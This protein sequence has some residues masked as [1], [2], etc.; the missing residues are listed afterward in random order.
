MQ[1]TDTHAHLYLPQFDDDREE[2][3][4]RALENGVT[5]I[6]LPNI[7]AASVEPMLQLATHYPGICFPMI[8]LHPTSVKE[9]YREQLA[10]MK[11]WLEKEKFYAI[12]EVGI[13]L[14]WD[15]SKLKEQE[16]A[17]SYQVELSITNDLPLVIHCRESFNE[18]VTIL[19][20]YR[21]ENIK[22]VFHAFSGTSEQAK[23]VINMGFLL[24]IGGVVTFKNGGIDKILAETGPS[25]LLTE[26]DSPYLAPAPFRGKRNEPSMIRYTAEKIAEFCRLPL[27]EIAAITTGNAETLFKI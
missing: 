13:D 25:R 21:G 24:G 15:K 8:G 22:G 16:E 2:A 20:R 27:S 14:Y 1:L 18:T 6:L 10:A 7:D 5:R 3:V 12:G 19:E 17:F 26:T 9:D 4:L 23:K 11:A